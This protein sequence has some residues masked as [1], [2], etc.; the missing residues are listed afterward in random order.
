MQYDNGFSLLKSLHLLLFCFLV[1]SITR[2]SFQLSSFTLFYYFYRKANGFF[3]YIP[4][5]SNLPLLLTQQSNQQRICYIYFFPDTYDNS[6]SNNSVHDDVNTRI[7]VERQWQQQ[8]WRQSPVGGKERAA[9]SSELRAQR[10]PQRAQI[11][12][13]RCGGNSLLV[14]LLHHP[15]VFLS[16]QRA[17]ITGG[18]RRETRVDEKLSV[19]VHCVHNLE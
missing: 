9:R 17:N 11:T 5:T 10:Q 18:I 7:H 13:R 19:C 14:L 1:F 15:V 16:V 2:V 12:T 3:F 4:F 6:C 8:R